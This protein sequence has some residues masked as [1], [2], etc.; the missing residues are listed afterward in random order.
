MGFFKFIFTFYTLLNYRSTLKKLKTILLLSIAFRVGRILI[1][2]PLNI[3]I[4]LV[5]H[6][7]VNIVVKVLK[8][9]GS[10]SINKRK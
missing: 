10:F 8:Y 9:V 7:G 2:T 1:P 6:T 5:D 4:G 3:H